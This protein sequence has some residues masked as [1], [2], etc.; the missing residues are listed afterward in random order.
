MPFSPDPQQDRFVETM[1]R[2]NQKYPQQSE[3]KNEV[4]KM[5]AT[6]GATAPDPALAGKM[7]GLAT[8]LMMDAINK[9]QAISDWSAFANTVLP[10]SGAT[11]AALLGDT[12]PTA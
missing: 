12:K 9:N 4:F 10:R 5:M 11:S 8:E 2:Y 7:K 3:R 1:A 6:M